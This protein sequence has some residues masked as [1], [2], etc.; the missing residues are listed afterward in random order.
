MPHPSP[1]PSVPALCL[2][3]HFLSRAQFSLMCEADTIAR[4]LWDSW[5]E[6]I[7]GGARYQEEPPQMA[8]GSPAV[9]MGSGSNSY[10]GQLVKH[11]PAARGLQGSVSSG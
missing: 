2:E 3:R 10:H 6:M 7:S 8:G 4:P 11:T 5:Q 9:G 1:V